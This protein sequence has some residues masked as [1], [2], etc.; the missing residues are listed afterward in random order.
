MLGTTNAVGGSVKEHTAYADIPTQTFAICVETGRIPWSI[1]RGIT[2]MAVVFASTRRNAP[3]RTKLPTNDEITQ[4]L[5]QGSSLPP[6][7]NPTSCTERPRIRRRAPVRSTCFQTL[8]PTAVGDFSLL[9]IT[10]RPT[11]RA[12]MDT[13]TCRR[14]HHLH[15]IVFAIEPPSDA[16]QMDPNP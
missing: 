8:S 10:M 16:P 2:G 14:K 13:G 5:V 15:P 7:L 11:I 4:I 3:N 9:G 12:K 6:R 1:R